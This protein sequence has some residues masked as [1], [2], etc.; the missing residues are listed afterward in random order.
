MKSPD[1]IVSAIGRAPAPVLAA[2]CLAVVI[3]LSAMDI[4]WNL[5][6]QILLF[7]VL[8]FLV[9]ALKGSLSREAESARRDPLTGALNGKAFVEF[10]WRE[11]RRARRYKRQ[12]TFAYMD[13]DNFKE[14]NDHFGHAVGDSLLLQVTGA[15]KANLRNVDSLS[16]L[17]GDEFA[18]MLPETAH[19]GAIV[20]MERLRNLMMDVMKKNGWPATFSIGVVSYKNPPDTVDEMIKRA[21][22]LMYQAKAAGKDMIRY[23]VY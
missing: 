7:A 21:D 3:I 22:A 1:R 13:I 9:L 14:M 2:G 11:I 5:A 19:D 18:I 23:D 10:A 15:I 16:R 6:V 17:G 12:F 8:L 20:V 4:Y